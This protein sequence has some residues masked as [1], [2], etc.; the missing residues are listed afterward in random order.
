[1]NQR[2]HP[3]WKHLPT[4]ASVAV[5]LLPV[6]ILILWFDVPRK[7]IGQGAMAYAVGAVGIKLPLYHLLVARVLHK[8]LSNRSLA[9]SQGAISAF[10]ELG[11]ALGFFLF[12]VP[13]LTFAELIGF[14]VAAGSVE[15]I[16]LP[17]MKNPLE[18]TPLEAH[19]GETGRKASENMAV[20]WLGVVERVLASVIHTA[21]RCLTYVSS[22]TGNP[23]PM[24]LALVGFAS[25]DGRAYY[26]HL[27]KWQFDN[28]Q[29]LTKFYRFLGVVACSL[30]VVFLSL[31][32]WLVLQH[33]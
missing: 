18:G 22:F 2:L 28:T 11:A 8:K 24:V 16:I 4:A 3:L 12:V 7:V 29:V 17:F 19:A 33:P 23:V 13:E 30:T 31:Y 21:T 32:Y 14:G 1:M 26:A 9:L 6:I 5:G 25:I 20:Q 15:A 10:S 27:E